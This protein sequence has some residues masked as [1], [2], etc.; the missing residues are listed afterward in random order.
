M[1][2]ARSRSVLGNVAIANELKTRSRDTIKAVEC[3]R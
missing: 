2:A 3:W 1:A